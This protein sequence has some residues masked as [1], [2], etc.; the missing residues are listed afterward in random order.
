MAPFVPIPGGA[1][2]YILF[3]LDGVTIS[4]RLWFWTD[5]ISPPGSTELQGLADGVYS[6]HTSMIMPYL[7]QDLLLGTVIAYDW[8]DPSTPF[9][10]TTGPSIN[11]DVAENSHSANVALSVGF[12]WPI[13][14]PHLKRNKNF[15]PGVALSDINLNT[16]TAFIQ[17]VLFE[18]Y[19]A[20]IDDARLFSPGDY[21]Y[22]VV[23]SAWED[24]VLRSEQLIAPSIGPVPR[25][26]IIIGQRRKRLPAS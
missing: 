6:W 19:A 15:V 16:P 5:A 9:E 2:V 12:R 8:S 3:N 21:W 13:N 11:G 23:A 25:E 26:K 4:N 22:W 17:D 20:L 10:T 7:S 24:N 14:Y 1:Q 18:A